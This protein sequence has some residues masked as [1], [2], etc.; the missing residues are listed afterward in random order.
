MSSSTLDSIVELSSVETNT[1]AQS[2]ESRKWSTVYEASVL[3]GHSRSGRGQEISAGFNTVRHPRTAFSEHFF[4]LSFIWFL[5]SDWFHLVVEMRT[6]KILFV[7]AIIY[8]SAILFFSLWWYA[9]GM[10]TGDPCE[11]G[12]ENFTDAFYFS[13]ITF[14]TIGYGASSV[15]FGSCQSVPALVVCESFTGLLVH[16]L[17]MGIIFA[18]TQRGNTRGYSI[19]YSKRCLLR[20]I[21]GEPH[22]IFRVC[23]ARKLQLM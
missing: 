10:T 4:D 19:S 9:L 8:V 20:M 16:S 17:A 11:T 3:R 23:E 12:I 21:K 6:G 7:L 18:K 2:H 15:F 14:T 1:T 13:T 22:I 5:R